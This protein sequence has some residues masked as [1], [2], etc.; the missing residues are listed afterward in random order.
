MSPPVPVCLSPLRSVRSLLRGPRL[1]CGGSG[2]SSGAPA[3]RWVEAPGQTGP[4]ASSCSR[5]GEG[6]SGQKA[7]LQPWRTKVVPDP[8]LPSEGGAGSP[9]DGHHDDRTSNPGG[10]APSDC[11]TL[12]HS[13][14]EPPTHPSEEEVE[15]LHPEPSSTFSSVGSD[16]LVVSTS[17]RCPQTKSG[18]PDKISPQD[19]EKGEEQTDDLQGNQGKADEEPGQGHGEAQPASRPPPLES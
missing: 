2:G 6:R 9:S 11:S 17:L 5:P 12:S 10:R 16:H 4:T 8:L 18:A 14:Q 1:T 19:H 7:G 15:E 3:H 13:Y